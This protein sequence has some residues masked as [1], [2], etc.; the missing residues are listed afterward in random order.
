MKHVIIWLLSS[1]RKP[2]TSSQLFSPCTLSTMTFLTRK[3]I[4]LKVEIWTSIILTKQYANVIL[5]RASENKVAADLIIEHLLQSASSDPSSSSSTALGR[6]FRL[7]NHSESA[8]ST[9][10]IRPH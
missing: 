9:P 2:V 6:T 7:H 10:S 8:V 1:R 4:W 5:P 3:S